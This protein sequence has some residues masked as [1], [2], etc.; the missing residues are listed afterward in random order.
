M[1]NLTVAFFMNYTY[2]DKNVLIDY[3]ALH[4]NQLTIR[5]FLPIVPAA[6]LALT[7]FF[8][9]AHT[10][11]AGNSPV[12]TA[13]QTVA[14]VVAG[15]NDQ[16]AATTTSTAN[17]VQVKAT[18]TLTV[19]SA[20]LTTNT[21]TVGSCV[22]TFATTTSGIPA[23]Q[24][25]NCADNVAQ[26]TT[27]TTSV[28]IPKTT[29]QIANDILSL[30]NLVDTANGHA[31]L[32]VTASSTSV[33]SAVFTTT[34]TEASSTAIKFTD[35]TAGKIITAAGAGA[36]VSGVVAVAQVDTTTIGGTVDTGDTFTLHLP[37]S[38]DATYTVA[39][40]DTTT[41]NIATGLSAAV[42]ASAGYSGQVFTSSISTNTVLLTAKTAGTSFVDATSSVTNRSAV[43]QQVTF[44]PS[45]VFLGYIFTATINGS[46]YGYTESSVSTVAHVVAGVAAALASVP[47]V[48]CS[49]DGIKVTCTASAPGTAFTYAGAVTASGVS[50]SG[51][52]GGGGRYSYVAPTSTARVTNAG[53]PTSASPSF[54]HNLAVGAK[55][56]DVR[57]LQVYLNTH[58][59]TVSAAGPGSID[60]ETTLFG[61]ATKAALAKFQAAHSIRPAVGYLG[62]KTRALLNSL[63]L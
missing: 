2:R 32:T 30:A 20:P 10:S 33:T 45:N 40:S 56:A 52:S 5:S 41:S 58:G 24:D 14:N 26:I 63:G 31:A 16:T 19:S 47:G 48:S 13:S 1:N 18:R 8:L 49:Q 22:V 46:D 53:T 11:H 15:T 12:L 42:Q 27:A 35:G 59:F 28:D 17:V 57:A 61:K 44:T 60:H 29:T 25:L 39:S 36:N 51:G 54:S 7:F 6:I 38:V 50:A 43:A 37:G 21:I 55:G 9:L 23:T 34:G 4:M 3:L 62:P